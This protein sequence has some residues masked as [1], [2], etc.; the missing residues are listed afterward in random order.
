MKA[1]GRGS[2]LVM[3]RGATEAMRAVMTGTPT[4][5]AAETGMNSRAVGTEEA[6]SSRGGPDM[7]ATAPTSP[8]P[9]PACG[10]RERD[11]QPATSE[12]GKRESSYEESREGPAPLRHQHNLLTHY[13]FSK[14][15]K[16]GKSCGGSAP[17]N[18]DVVTSVVIRGSDRPT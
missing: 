4:E 11:R 9:C 5:S 7:G 6:P 12:R 17:E 1:V 14:R 15:E 13:S 16:H 2:E 8:E 3:S 10:V 18:Q